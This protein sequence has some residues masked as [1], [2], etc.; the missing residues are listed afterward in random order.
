MLTPRRLTDG[1]QAAE[2]KFTADRKSLE[3]RVHRERMSTGAVKIMLHS[4]T[5]IK[6]G[7]PA[8]ATPL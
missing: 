6:A 1:R 2:G 4:Q 5:Q 8:S 3:V 7:S